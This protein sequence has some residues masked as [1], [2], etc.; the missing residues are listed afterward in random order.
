MLLKAYYP[1]FSSIVFFGVYNCT[2]WQ[3]IMV[4]RVFLYEATM[5]GYL[6]MIDNCAECVVALELKYQKLI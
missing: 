2:T 6:T 1:E 4:K 3:M 5:A